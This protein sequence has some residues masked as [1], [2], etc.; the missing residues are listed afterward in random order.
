MFPG[1]FVIQVLSNFFMGSAVFFLLIAI[2]V[3]PIVLLILPGTRHLIVSLLETLL[4][5]LI[6]GSIKLVL[7]YGVFDRVLVEHGNPAHPQIFSIFW[8]VFVLLNFVQAPILGLFRYIYLILV[9]LFRCTLIHTST[10]NEDWVHLDPGYY[11][12][13]ALTF[14]QSSRRNLVRRAFISL[15]MP[16][17]Q[18]MRTEE[19]A[20]K[21]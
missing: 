6:A 21:V 1:Q 17:V 5:P 11:S 10:L 14:T 16:Q 20:S 2:I 7:K 4:L 19:P 18:R 13:L 15:L 8:I 3:T 9:A 12:F